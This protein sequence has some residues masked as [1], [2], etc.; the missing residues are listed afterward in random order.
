MN[1]NFL[2]TLKRVIAEHGE[3]ILADPRRLKSLI[4]D[5]AQDESK[6]ERQAFGRCIE[7]GAY[8]ALKTAPD[9][10]A[11][12]SRKAA[13]ARQVH[14]SAGLD[15][16][17]CAEALDILEAALYGGQSH[18]SAYTPAPHRSAS[19]QN[20]ALW[21]ALAAAA[22]I[23]VVVVGISIALR[24]DTPVNDG[25]YRTIMTMK[26][27]V[28]AAGGN[29]DG[30]LR[31]SIQWN[32]GGYNPNDFDAHCVEPDGNE[33]FFHAPDGHPSDGSLDVD[34]RYPEWGTPAVENITWPSTQ[35]MREGD[36]AFFVHCYAHNGGRGGFSAEI[37]YNGQLY[38]FTHDRELRQDE[39]VFVAVVNY[40]RNDGFK[41][42]RSPE[43][44]Q[45]VYIPQ[46]AL[47]EAER[48][49]ADFLNQNAAAAS[50][51][52]YRFFYNEQGEA[53]L[54]YTVTPK[55]RY[56]W[57]KPTWIGR[58]WGTIKGSIAKGN[59]NYT[60]TKQKKDEADYR[61]EERRKDRAFHEI[62][63]EVLRIAVEYDYDF[64]A[65]YGTSVQYRNPNVKKA[66]CEGY[67]AAVARTLQNHRLARDVETWTSARGN[68]AWNVIVLQDRRKLYCDATWYD[69]NTVD[70]EGYVVHEPA[71][72]PVDLTFD[73]AE[74]NSLGGAVDTSSGRLLA[75]HFAWGDAI[76][77]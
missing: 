22:L 39:E 25:E 17:L 71:R 9:A 2:A 65:A 48:F 18:K 46:Y 30:T 23:A 57:S 63:Q 67:A 3:S 70:D 14:D 47:E 45:E 20:K 60:M 68:H 55:G 49:K 66:V 31:F 40:S 28:K 73:M 62:E 11:R 35:K 61:M 21:Y 6:E 5:Y 44:P 52:A 54:E 50:D 56:T 27:R 77:K 42:V 7:Q 37:E 12:A 32:D 16:T 75:V 13:L 72:N 76:K 59:S 4:R 74:F 33:I 69:G 1:T 53:C 51:L 24:H 8:A 29:V 36:Y 10:A 58:T 41:L 64:Y 43:A 19:K 34:I 15:I 38:P 26:E